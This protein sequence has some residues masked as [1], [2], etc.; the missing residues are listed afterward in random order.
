MHAALAGWALGCDRL[1]FTAP[2]DDGEGLF[3]V[4]VQALAR[5]GLRREQIDYINAHGTGTQVND[6][7]EAVSLGRLLGG[8]LG[9]VPCS[10]T[11]PITGHCLG[12]TPALEAV[13]S[14]LALQHQCVPP[15]ANCTEPDP[16]CPIDAVGG[17]ARPAS[18][19]VVM[20]NSLGFWGNNAWLLFTGRSLPEEREPTRANPG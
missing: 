17:C 11:K 19:R 18:L 20:S 10:S 16:A 8:R 13:I 12:A 3:R 5:A 6:R 7:L 2:R 15:T 14:V 9:Q 1:H 4:M